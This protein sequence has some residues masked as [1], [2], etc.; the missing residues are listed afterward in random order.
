MSAKYT[1]PPFSRIGKG[2]V[3]LLKN[4]FPDT[5]KVEVETASEKGLSFVSLGERK[6]TKDGKDVVYAS[7]QPKFKVDKYGLEFKG[8]L[9][10]E[11]LFKSEF[12]VNDLLLPGLK[13]TLKAEAGKAQVIN[14]AF[15][16]SHEYFTLGTSVDWKGVGDLAFGFSLVTGHQGFSAGVQTAY[17]AQREADS[18]KE[19]GF[20]SVV[21]GFNYKATSHDI[22]LFLKR[23]TKEEGKDAEKKAVTAHSVQA[24]LHY[25]PNK[26]TSLATEFELDPAQ[27]SDLIKATKIKFGGTHKVD[28]DTTLR[29]R[30]DTDGKLGLSVSKQLNSHLNVTLGTEIN[31]AALSGEHKFGFKLGLKV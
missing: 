22:S 11:S 16:Y 6:K 9:D 2:A 1:P 30:F 17:F 31:T 28:A 4:D 12:T 23:E 15:D 18:K 13:T 24:K 14:A 5:Y 19:V 10:N 8:T 27:I 26:E 20:D 3:D 25:T 21:G 7:F 29:G